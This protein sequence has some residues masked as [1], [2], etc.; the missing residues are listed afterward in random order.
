MR[1]LI[2]AAAR[3]L[4]TARINRRPIDFDTAFPPY[5]PVVPAGHVSSFHRWQMDITSVTNRN[6]DVDDGEAQPSRTKSGNRYLNSRESPGVIAH[7]CAAWRLSNF[8]GVSV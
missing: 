1:S 3:G 4:E 6:D 2:A 5:R 7:C 8:H